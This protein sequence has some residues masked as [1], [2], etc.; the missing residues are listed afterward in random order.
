LSQLAERHDL[1]GQR[2][3]LKNEPE[4]IARIVAPVLD[5]I[6]ATDEKL[7]RDQEDY[8]ASFMVVRKQIDEGFLLWHRSQS[9]RGIRFLTEY[10]P[11]MSR[12]VERA[13]SDPRS[14]MRSV[15]IED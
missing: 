2:E 10:R 9:Q 14:L 11:D 1:E 5:R 12:P 13:P 15:E 8:A 7:A 3:R 6:A 4:P